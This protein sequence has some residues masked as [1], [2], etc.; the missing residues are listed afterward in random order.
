[1][2]PTRDRMIEGAARLL[3]RHGLQAT[4]FSE[5]LEATG[6]PRGSIYHYFPE[7]KH[8]LIGAAIDLVGTRAREAL[9]AQARASA[10]T[11]TAAFLDQ[12]RTILVRSHLAAGCAVL[13]VTVAADSADLL[14]RAG[15]VFRSWREQ[16]AGL[17]QQGGLG[18]SDAVRFA[19]LLVAASEGA[20]VLCR[21]EQ[22]MEPFDL[23]AEQL[24]DQA[25]GMTAR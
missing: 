16:L 5:V 24:L 2:S 13:A 18:P 25:R 3:A 10:E 15:A 14:R 22:S 4:S 7:G 6:A 21:A 12:W 17:L 23:V 1:M 19:A 20:V 9:G 11:V 8:Q